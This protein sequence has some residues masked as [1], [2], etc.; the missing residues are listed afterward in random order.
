[1][2]LIFSI[3]FGLAVMFKAATA[4][5]L[6][7]ISVDLDPGTAGI[8]S[9][10]IVAPGDIFTVDVV[11]TGDGVAV[12]DTFGFDVVFNNL[13][14][15]I[16]GLAGGTGSPTAGAIAAL[17]PVSAVD[18]FT[19]V[20]VAPGNALTPSGFPILPP[21]GFTA[22]SSLVGILSLAIPFGGGV[23]IGAGIE[24]DLFSL[25]LV[26]LAPGMSTLA[27]STG[28]VLGGLF[29]AGG[30][31]SLPFTLVSGSITVVPEPGT[32]LLMGVGLAGLAIWQRRRFK[33]RSSQ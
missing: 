11:Y 24:V 8:Q 13:G 1:M 7:I 16:L 10:L 30:V 4:S 23:P 15:G 5:A 31:P 33:G 12:F 20:A 2:R 17:A 19:F 28:G 29:L 6:P 3:I 21:A 22:H 9:V 27:A 26:A 18:A 14:A 32:F 25:D